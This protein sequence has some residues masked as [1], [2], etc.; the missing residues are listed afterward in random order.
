VVIVDSDFRPVALDPGA[1]AILC[2]LAEH[3]TS[4]G[5]DRVPQAILNLLRSKQNGGAKPMYVR[6][7]AHCYSC[8]AFEIRFLSG[9]Q[10]L[11]ALY[12]RQEMSLADSA[13]RLAA[14]HHLSEREKEAVI[15]LAMGLSCKEIAEKMKISPNTAKVFVRMAMIKTGASSRAA[16]F[17]R[18]LNR[19]NA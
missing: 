8:R 3:S 4:D 2:S 17:T 18:L 19:Q 12:L 15:G 7:A 16:L 6:S 11:L 13:H 5:M 10:P 9:A 1:E 14:D